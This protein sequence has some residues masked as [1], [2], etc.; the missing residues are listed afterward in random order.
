MTMETR[1]FMC[2]F[3]LTF[4][5]LLTVW[6]T[7]RVSTSDDLSH[8]QGCSAAALR[9]CHFGYVLKYASQHFLHYKFWGVITRIHSGL[10]HPSG[11]RPSV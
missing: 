6:L 10:N 4:T 9:Q 2:S 5:Y 7:Y 3:V 1:H 11:L 8:L